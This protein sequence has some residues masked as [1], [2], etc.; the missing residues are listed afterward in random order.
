LPRVEAFAGSDNPLLRRFGVVTLV[1]GADDLTW[2]GAMVAM[3]DRLK[4][5]PDEQVQ[6]AVERARRFLRR[7]GA[8]I[9]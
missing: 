3:I 5:D 6:K 7:R 1:E 4:G 2:Q 8:K 9:G